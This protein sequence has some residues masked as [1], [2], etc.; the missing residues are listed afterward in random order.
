MGKLLR[1]REPNGRYQR[2]RNEEFAPANVMRL[3]AAALRET[4]LSEWGSQ[5][6]R[7][8]LWAQVSAL[9]YGAAKRW[10]EQAGLYHHA[11]GS[12][13]L[14]KSAQLERGVFSYPADPDSERGRLQ[15]EQDRRHR[16]HYE[17]ALRVL[18]A[19]GCRSVVDRVVLEDLAPVG[20]EGLQ[21]LK[22][23]LAAL[24]EHWGRKHER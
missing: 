19:S 2:E 3:R 1:R 13:A 7:L 18:E 15:A 17:R 4:R 6:G 9:E 5:I 20:I 24:A 23:G 22:R 12:P 11:N 14:M 8:Y 16:L 10:A 21:Q